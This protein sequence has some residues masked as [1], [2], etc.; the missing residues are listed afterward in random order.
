MVLLG[1]VLVFS[2]MG[3]LRGR[4]LQAFFNG[5]EVVIKKSKLY[6]FASA[7]MARD[8]FQLSM[9]QMASSPSGSTKGLA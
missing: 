1:Q 8:L 9:R 2:F 4:I 3:N 5:T 6:H 7:D